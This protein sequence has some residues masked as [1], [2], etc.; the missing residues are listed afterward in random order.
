MTTKNKHTDFDLIIVG[1][2][3]AGLVAARS[4]ALRGLRVAVLEKKRDPSEKLHTTGILVKEAARALDIPAELTRPIHSVRLYAP[5]LRAIDLAAPGYYF[6]ASDTGPL[7]RWLAAEAARAGAM[8]L[9]DQPFMGATYDGEGLRLASPDITTR[10]LI[11]ADGARSRVAES[12]GLGRNRR[13]LRGA[14]LE[15][16]LEDFDGAEAL[17][18]FIDGQL[19]PGYIT[20]AVP[21]VKSLQVGLARSGK[22]PIDL[23]GLVVKLK[24]AGLLAPD[25]QSGEGRAGLIPAGGLRA[26]F[27]GRHVLLIGDAA[28]L[29]SPVTGGGIFNAFH[30][31]RQAALAVADHLLLDAPEP[32]RVLAPDL[33]K[34]RLKGALRRGFDLGVPDFLPNLLLATPP[35][36]AFARAL[37]FHERGAKA[38]A[39]AD[40]YYLAEGTALKKRA[41]LVS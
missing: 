32:S 17:H 28:G 39:P 12:F 26:P 3:F 2:S 38:L 14:E 35:F 6:L 4:A 41:T 40:R 23:Q 27:A 10:Y 33:P 34:Y 29:V 20:W 21:G 31:G 13:F 5:N 16:P 19:A 22:G 37:Y 18:C 7:L 30:F 36:R 1:A 11:G 15:F 8:L 24:A 9:L 25:A